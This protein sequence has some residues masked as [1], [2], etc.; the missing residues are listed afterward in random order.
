MTRSP[1]ATE[2]PVTMPAT[3]ALTTHNCGVGI[4][5]WAG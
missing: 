5:I 2:R 4:T 3:G 1:R